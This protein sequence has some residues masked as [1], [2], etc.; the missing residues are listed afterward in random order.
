MDILQ[1]KAF[2]Q[3]LEKSLDLKNTIKPASELIFE[4]FTHFDRN[5]KEKVF[6][7]SSKYDKKL[8]NTIILDNINKSNIGYLISSIHFNRND[9]FTEYCKRNINLLDYREQMELAVFLI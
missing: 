2:I 1:S 5:L 9:I 4:L 6:F 7:E 3:L 8:S